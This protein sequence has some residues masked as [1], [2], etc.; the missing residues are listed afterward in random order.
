LNSTHEKISDNLVKLPLTNAVA[1][2]TFSIEYEAINVI[3]KWF[4]GDPAKILGMVIAAY[5]WYLIHK[6]ID[7]KRGQSASVSRK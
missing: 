6:T 3:T 4:L 2:S 5:Q 1:S 7:G